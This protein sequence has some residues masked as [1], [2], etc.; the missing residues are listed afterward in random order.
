MK[1]LANTEMAMPF[2]PVKSGATRTIDRAKQEANADVHRPDGDRDKTLTQKTSVTE[3]GNEIGNREQRRSQTSFDAIVKDADELNATAD[4][5]SAVVEVAQSQLSTLSSELAALV[6]GIQ[7]SN[8]GN[9]HSAHNAAADSQ[10]G[11][12]TVSVADDD[13]A[14]LAEQLS[15]RVAT[16]NRIAGPSNETVSRPTQQA[17]APADGI[18]TVSI[19]ALQ[20]ST[21]FDAPVK[22]TMNQQKWFQT[23]A[24]ALAGPSTRI[25][26][27]EAKLSP[28]DANGVDKAST[29]VTLSGSASASVENLVEVTQRS[30]DQGAAKQ[31][32]SDQDSREGAKRG[33]SAESSIGASKA[34][35]AVKEFNVKD[36]NGGVA[37]PYQQIRSAVG[38]AILS[39]NAVQRT[40]YVSLYAD[41]PTTS[42]LTLKTLEISLEPPDLG[43]VN[44]KM[45][46][47]ARDLKLE[48]EASKASTAQML[49]NDQAALKLELLSDNSDLSSVLVSVTNAVS[50][51]GASRGATNGDQQFGGNSR[52]SSDNTFASPN[53]NGRE[54]QRHRQ[55]S[56]FQESGTASRQ[57]E[58]TSED[59]HARA[60]GR[61]LYI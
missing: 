29:E 25:L 41:R 22:V 23:M 12:A 58:G 16:L 48:I 5:P 53:G 39:A 28:L 26:P 6:Q 36:G 52:T 44:V 42:T 49:S 56:G 59:A 54:E 21:G 55:S 11:V 9:D 10:H 50:D 31:S 38:E 7:A 14:R 27:V 13:M 1:P 19:S 8:S 45:N 47:A 3:A 24:P 40:D 61:A 15:A 18:A 37:A 35:A 17:V 46:L 20:T 51:A 34:S 32:D 30:G 43:R 60:P 33:V 4:T 2:A 57:R